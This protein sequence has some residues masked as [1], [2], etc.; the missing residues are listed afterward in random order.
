[1]D[2]SACIYD[3]KTGTC[4]QRLREH[5]DYVQRVRFHP[6]GNY[7]ATASCDGTAILWEANT[8]KIRHKLEKHTNIVG[9]ISFSPDGRN[10]A[11]ASVDENIHIWNT[12]SGEILYSLKNNGNRISRLWMTADTTFLTIGYPENIARLWDVYTGKLLWKKEKSSYDFDFHPEGVQFLDRAGDNRFEVWDTKRNVLIWA[13]RMKDKI[14]KLRYSPNGEFVICVLQ[15]GTTE[16]FYSEDGSLRKVLNEKIDWVTFRSDGAYFAGETKTEIFIWDCEDWDLVSA[17]EKNWEGFSLIQ[18]VW[19]NHFIKVSPWNRGI[20]LL[21][22]ESGRIVNLENTERERILSE[23]EDF[24]VTV[25]EKN[26]L[27]TWDYE[28]GKMKQSIT[29]PSGKIENFTCHPQRGLTAILFENGEIA[30]VHIPTEKI[31][32]QIP[33]I[34]EE[35]WNPKFSADGETL[36][37]MSG[38]ILYSLKWKTKEW[39][40]A[41]DQRYEE[42]LKGCNVQNAR[43]DEA[44]TRADIAL[45]KR[46]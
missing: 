9:A 24:F 2:N 3:V 18:F 44:L 45:L 1:M 26:E 39:G 13:K 29:L 10:L 42:R 6:E 17:Y 27:K 40:I 11:T 19:D 46:Y 30:I 20:Y 31:L 32:V 7:L 4:L 22:F 21:D 37:V 25:S 28:T 41:I 33:A 34:D 16:I 12:S 15:D 8:G 5:H 14:R 38:P 35:E 23:G 36:F 43:F